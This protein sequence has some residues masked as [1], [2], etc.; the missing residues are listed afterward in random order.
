M[1][2]EE[3][4]ELC[5]TA[6]EL[7][8]GGDLHGFLGLIA[9]DVTWQE[10]YMPDAEVYHGREGARSW[11]R[12]MSGTLEQTRFEPLHFF[13]DGDAVVVEVLE[14]GRGASSGAET[15]A[16]LAHAVRVRE[17]RFV[18]LG[19]FPGVAEALAAVGLEE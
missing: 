7:W 2:R 17:S 16:R 8:N 3:N 4:L 13:A 5:R 1:S 11:M 9:E 15:S 18:Y 10:G 12:A 6:Y 14:H 19:A